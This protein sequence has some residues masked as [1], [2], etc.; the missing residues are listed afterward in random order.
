MWK[1]QYSVAYSN[2][3]LLNVSNDCRN[4]KIIYVTLCQVIA[5]HKLLTST[6]NT[7]LANISDYMFKLICF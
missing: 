7:I 5:K 1:N 2:C 4:V 3:G 6:M